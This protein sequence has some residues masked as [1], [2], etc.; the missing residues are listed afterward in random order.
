VK[1]AVPTNK[2]HGQDE[3]HDRQ[4]LQKPEKTEKYRRKIHSPN[5]LCP[6]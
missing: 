4:Q 6:L 1:A 3:G 2:D 5:P